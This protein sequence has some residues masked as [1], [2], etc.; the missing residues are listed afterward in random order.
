M[1]AAA[2]IQPTADAP[3]RQA[4]HARIDRQNLSALRLSLADPVTPE[5][6]SA[7]RPASWRLADIRAAMM[8][9]GDLITAKKAERRVLVLENP[10]LRG[11][12]KIITPLIERDRLR[13]PSAIRLVGRHRRHD[14][15]LSSCQNCR[16]ETAPHL[17]PAVRPSHPGAR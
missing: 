2:I 6:R 13:V 1:Q 9:A 5:P 3:E 7:C 14:G 15:P 12:S 8:E 11:Q 17:A 4:F 16:R 10:G